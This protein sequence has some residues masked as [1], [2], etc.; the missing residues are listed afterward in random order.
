MRGHPLLRGFE[1][2]VTGMREGSLT[3]APGAS[4]A[5]EPGSWHVMLSEPNRLLKAGDTVKL[6][7]T[8]GPAASEFAFTVKA[9][10]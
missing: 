2:G 5:L 1:R 10:E 4:A 7:L 8:C 6:A 9:A 3:L